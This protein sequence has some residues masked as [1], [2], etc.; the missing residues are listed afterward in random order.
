MIKIKE[1]LMAL[2][3]NPRLAELLK[4]AKEPENAEEAADQYASAAEKL[5]VSLSKEEVLTFLK[6]EEEQVRS[7]TEKAVDM[8]KLSAEQLDHVA[9]GDGGY[10]KDHP[11]C[12][13]TYSD[14]EWCWF[15]DN[16]SVI[17]SYYD[18]STKENQFVEGDCDQNMFGDKLHEDILTP[19]GDFF[20]T[21]NGEIQ[22]WCKSLDE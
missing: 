12:D 21:G 6:D 7:K 17:I 9:G 19:D 3:K 16:C 4:G 5:G 15:S 10:V 8:V 14:H 1:C 13:T 18:D 2:R 22:I 11:E 20:P